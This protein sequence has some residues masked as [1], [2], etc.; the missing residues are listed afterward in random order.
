MP[1]VTRGFALYLKST[2][3]YAAGSTPAS[4]RCWTTSTLPVAAAVCRGL[5]FQP[6]S[7]SKK[8]GGPSS[9]L[10]NPAHDRQAPLSSV[11]RSQGHL[12]G[13][14]CRLMPHPGPCCCLY[15]TGCMVPGLLCTSLSGG[16]VGNMRDDNQQIPT[17]QSQQ[18]GRRRSLL[19]ERVCGGQSS[20]QL[21]PLA[22]G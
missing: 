17:L 20:D 10:L 5:C 21:I 19:C 6:R 15:R 18:A 8:A 3:R 22:W 9:W 13:P 14:C 7:S 1:A 12:P 16:G 11:A 2:G 4:S